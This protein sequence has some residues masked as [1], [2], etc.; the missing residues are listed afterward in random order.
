MEMMLDSKKL[1]LL[2][3]SSEP[4]CRGLQKLNFDW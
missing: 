4:R 2:E 3:Q 1:Y